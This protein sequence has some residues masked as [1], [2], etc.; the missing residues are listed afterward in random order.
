MDLKAMIPGE[1]LEEEEDRLLALELLARSKPRDLPCMKAGQVKKL[2]AANETDWRYLR[3]YE[4]LPG[5][6]ERKHS[7]M[8]FSVN[9]V[10]ILRQLMILRRLGAPYPVLRE[11]LAELQAHFKPTDPTSVQAKFSL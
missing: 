2:I 11:K 7:H 6:A 9:D 1:P 4:L 10:Y 3:K 8:V 5:L